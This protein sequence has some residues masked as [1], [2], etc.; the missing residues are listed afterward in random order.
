MHSWTSDYNPGLSCYLM[1]DGTLLRTGR[2]TGMGN[3]SG[4]VEMID[5][6]G[7]VIWDYTAINTHGRQHHDIELLPNGNILLIVWDERS[8]TEVVDAGSSTINPFINSEQIIEI[9]PNLITGEATVVWEWKAW[10]HLIQDEDAGRDNFGVVGD[11]PELIDVNF[12]NH[13]NTDWLHFNGKWII[14]PN[15]TRLLSA[16]TISA[17]FGSSISSTS[18]SEAASS[19]GGAYGKGGDLLYRWGIPISYDQGL[20]GDQR[21][22]LQHHSQLD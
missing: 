11:H 13:N 20:P 22:F 21:L 14:I 19:T 17:S 3:G 6:N 18:T 9:E 7:N 4:I 8:Q 12:L 1:E 10:D 16:P 15:L 5:W 2:I